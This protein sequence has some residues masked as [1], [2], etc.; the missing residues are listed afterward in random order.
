M[1]RHRV[2]ADWNQHPLL[3]VHNTVEPLD[4]T[5][6]LVRQLPLPSKSLEYFLEP[7]ILGHDTKH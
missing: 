2:V 5:V 7:L 3:A 4:V 1:S 6:K